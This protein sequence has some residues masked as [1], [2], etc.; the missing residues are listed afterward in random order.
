MHLPQ[1]AIAIINRIHNSAESINI[2]NR[3]E[4]LI[5]RAHFLVNFIE[6]FSRPQIRFVMPTLSRRC[7]ISL[8]MR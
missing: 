3:M 5:F 7:E 8:D 2:H 4:F 6:M 1:P